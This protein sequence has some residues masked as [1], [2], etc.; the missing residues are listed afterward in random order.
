MQE[1]AEY[2][3]HEGRNF[4][5]Y[6]YLGNFLTEEGCTFRVWAPNAKE[7]YVTGDFCNWEPTKFAMKR[8]NDNGIYEIT[9]PGIKQFDSYKY[10]II[11][12]NGMMIILS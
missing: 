12:Y 4:H 11:P 10:V 6:D 8:I 3:F 2:L 1:M 5:S 9:I 7:V